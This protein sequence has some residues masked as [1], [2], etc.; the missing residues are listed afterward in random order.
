MD[1]DGRKERTE[2]YF[3][4]DITN[5]S[6]ISDTEEVPQYDPKQDKTVLVNVNSNR[7]A[8]TVPG[9]RF[10]CSMEQNEY[11]DRSIR[12]MQSKLREK[13]S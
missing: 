7:F 12:G 11:T 4:K 1:E 6:T 2:T 10:Y 8:I 3:Y 9:D 5:F 13:K